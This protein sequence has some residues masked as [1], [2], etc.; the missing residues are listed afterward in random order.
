MVGAGGAVAE[1]ERRAHAHELRVVHEAE[2]QARLVAVTQLRATAAAAAAASTVELEPL[3]R[4]HEWQALLAR[5]SFWRDDLGRARDA[6]AA[7][8][9][10]P[11]RALGRVV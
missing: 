6:T 8:A 9:A 2:A 11:K 10:S 3:R 5:R 1:H 4:R 7:A